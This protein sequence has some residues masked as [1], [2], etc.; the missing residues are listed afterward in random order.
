MCVNAGT[1]FPEVT[2]IVEVVALSGQQFFIFDEIGL[3]SQKLNV[4]DKTRKPIVL[5]H[6][7]DG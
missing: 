7:D 3:Q 2:E 1:S 5:H 4:P 6:D